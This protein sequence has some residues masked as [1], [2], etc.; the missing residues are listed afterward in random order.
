MNRIKLGHSDLQVTPVCLGTMTFGEQVSEAD[1]FAIMDRALERG[2]NFWD[3]AEMY[4]VNPVSKE[5][6]GRTESIIGTWF[7]ARGGRERVV[8]ATKIAG[9]APMTWARPEGGLDDGFT[10]HTKKQI[11]IA[12]AQSLK[13]LQTDYLDLY[14][15]HWP[16]RGYAG[17]GFHTFR[18]YPQDW[19]PFEAIL[20]A[21]APYV[22]KGVIRALG[23]SNESPWG[24]MRF[25]KA[26]W[27]LRMQKSAGRLRIILYLLLLNRLFC[28]GCAVE[29]MLEAQ[30]LYCYQKGNRAFYLSSWQ[31]D[32]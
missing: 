14:Q 11:D 25:L 4:P 28:R 19:L 2:V 6:A 32:R 26:V 8:L 1:A 30:S 15:L 12:V 18:D 22:E 13:R 31:F 10:R 7:A 23:V 21:L 9:R 17:F 24:V 3:T 29:W 5:T 16:D 20:D 27:R